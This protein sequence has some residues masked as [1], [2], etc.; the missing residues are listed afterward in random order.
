MTG[1]T[2]AHG[3]RARYVWDRCRCLP[4]RS[5]NSLYQQDLYRRQGNSKPYRVRA[6][7]NGWWLVRAWDGE[8]EGAVHLKTRD[9]DEAFR[10]R[11]ALIAAD[12][13][14]REGMWAPPW[15]V[16]EMRAHLRALAAHGVGL[17][18]ISTVSGVSRSRLCE[19]AGGAKRIRPETVEAILGVPLDAARGAGLVPAAP[20]WRMIGCLLAA[21]TTKGKIAQALG[22]KRPALQLNREQILARTARRVAELHDAA[23]RA[24]PKVRAVCACAVAA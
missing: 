1:V 15:L 9:R 2:R 17:R 13:G 20:A 4:C 5:A 14:E 24:S 6:V 21:G 12:S 23:W 22:A 7:G 10:H 8:H 16:R 19:I 11:D 18:R 3:T